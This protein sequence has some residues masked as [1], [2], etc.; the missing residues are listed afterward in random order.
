LLTHTLKALKDDP[1]MREIVSQKL[2]ENKDI[3]GDSS[4]VQLAME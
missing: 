2:L 4:L 1:A 3:S